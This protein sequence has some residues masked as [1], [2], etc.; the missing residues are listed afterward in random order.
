MTL[1]LRFTLINISFLRKKGVGTRW[2]KRASH[3]SHN[4]CCPSL[5]SQGYVNSYRCFFLWNNEFTAEE[6]KLRAVT[7]QWFSTSWM[8]RPAAVKNYLIKKWSYGC[9]GRVSW[10]LVHGQQLPWL[11]WPQHLIV[12]TEAMF[13][14]HPPCTVHGHG[15]V[16]V[17]LQFL[18]YWTSLFSEIRDFAHNWVYVR[19][20][21]LFLSYDPDRP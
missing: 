7:R 17:D 6:V 4:S 3:N 15:L 13:S 8:H 9:C 11:L 10:L 5:N 14:H 1:D 18:F 2:S 21:V 19:L 20:Q 16:T 12:I